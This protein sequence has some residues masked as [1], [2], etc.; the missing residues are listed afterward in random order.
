MQR[1]CVAA[2]VIAAIAIEPTQAHA[3]E[4]WLR[5]RTIGQAY[6][7][8]EYRLVGPD[9]FLG[10]RR[11]TQTLALRITDIGDLAERRRE[12]RLPDRG[13]TMSW[14]SYLR[15]DHDF[16]NYTSGRIRLSPAITRD[17]IDVIPELEDS[18]AGLEL[19]YGYVELA[20]LADDRLN[21]RLGR[22]LIDD[23]WGSSG[24]DGATV[25]YELPIPIAVSATA[26]LAV[27]ASSLLAASAFELDGTTGAACQE[28]VEGPTP[29]TGIW[30]L[31]DRGRAIRNTRFSSDYEF[32][33]Q[34]E[35]RQPTVGLAIATA[36]TRRIGAEVS[37]R[38][39]W[40]ETVGLIGDADRFPVPD[41]GLYP[42]ELG[43]APR[44]GLN[45]HRLAARI[46]GVGHAGSTELS[47]Y[48]NA[49][50]SLLHAAFDRA[51]TGI[52]VR[53]G[54]HELEPSVE[55]F[56]P[57]FDGDSIFNV[58][59]IEPTADV[60]LG[61]AYTGAVRATASGWLRRYFH[62]EGGSSVAG[63]VDAGIEH[64][65]TRRVRGRLDGLWDDG[66]GGRRVGGTAELG[67]RARPT[68]WLNGRVIVLG[69]R[70]EDRSAFV[71]SSG[72][73]SMSWRLGDAAALHVVGE[74]DHDEVHELQIRALA[75]LD[76]AFAPEL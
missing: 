22:M 16:G 71:T 68:L 17:A 57:S 72:V 41:T 8:R 44:S 45:A 63:G 10:R 54:D 49:R 40:S 58:F 70:R 19:M 56:L 43:Q 75:I 66:Y 4:F 47:P 9:L 7:L 23:G 69:V 6:Q 12:S 59:S 38:R 31:I 26:G 11:Y 1:V 48:A 21:A 65:I 55:Y 28:Y 64:A 37:Y 15:V 61:Y 24:V 73:T 36:R 14:H 30:Q 34:R 39:T 74:V 60:R 3:Y 2:V 50:F 46:H 27:R 25:R 67:W 52:R 29:G 76:L 53:R 42:N 20:G 5:A 18:M 51:D 35:M 13:L 62:A 33:P 32:C